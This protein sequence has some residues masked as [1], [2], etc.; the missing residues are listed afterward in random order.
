MKKLFA[1]L[2]MLA[3]TCSLIVGCG[4]G[5]DKKSTA[6]PAGNATESG[7]AATATGTP[8]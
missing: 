2:T 1:I 5:K 3:L 6:T 8:E 4:D 7:P